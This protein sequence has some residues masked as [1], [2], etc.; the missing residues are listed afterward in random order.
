MI[1]IRSL[2]RQRPLE[3]PENVRPGPSNKSRFKYYLAI[4]LLIFALLFIFIYY[5]ILL[6]KGSGF[7]VGDI[8]TIKSPFIGKIIHIKDINTRFK[9]GDILVEIKPIIAYDPQKFLELKRDEL[10]RI[11]KNLEKKKQ[12]LKTQKKAIEKEI[13]TANKLYLKRL[14]KI[15]EKYSLLSNLYSVE[16]QIFFINQEIERIKLE[17]IDIKNEIE[18]AK[19]KKKSY[20][21]TA[22]NSGFIL[23]K[24]ANKNSLV[25][26]GDY[27]LRISQGKP[28]YILAYFPIDKANFIF[29]GKKV[30]IQLSNG[31][32]IEGTIENIL[33]EA[34]T[35]PAFLIGPFERKN[36]SLQVIIKTDKINKLLLKEPVKIITYRY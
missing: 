7:V 28:K 31:K 35:K 17:L 3:I 9:K 1:H 26:P 30:K 33:P 29:K 12:Q 8:I 19:E 5:R 25:F 20:L 6:I 21:F 13:S 16:N 11:Y 24:S 36:L 22:K 32:K 23:Q 2:H 14:I 34:T 15:T 27:I 4:F 10:E 18:K